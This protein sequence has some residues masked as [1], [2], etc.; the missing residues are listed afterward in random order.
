MKN[1]IADMFKAS[2]VTHGRCVLSAAEKV[3]K[4]VEFKQGDKLITFKDNSLLVVKV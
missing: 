2:L 1:T 4:S 3:A